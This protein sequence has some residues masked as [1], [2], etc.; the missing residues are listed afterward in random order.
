LADYHCWKAL[1]VQIKVQMIVKTSL[2]F[3]YGKY[4]NA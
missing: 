2:R 3:G 1:E 4:G